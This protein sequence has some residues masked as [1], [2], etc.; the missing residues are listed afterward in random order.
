MSDIMNSSL[1]N[2]SSY[3]FED[4]R[5]VRTIDDIKNQVL[6]AVSYGLDIDSAY[7][8]NE[9]S[10]EQQDILDE[11]AAFQYRCQCAHKKK[12]LTLASSLERVRIQNEIRGISTESRF[13]LE[14]LYSDRWGNKQTV[15]NVPAEIPAPVVSRKT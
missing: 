15:S 10:Y 2:A 9:L 7:L 6:E 5:S 14:R 13:L 12:E 11:D 1:S 3:L 4:E 8:A